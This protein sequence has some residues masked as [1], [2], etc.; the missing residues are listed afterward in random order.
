MEAESYVIPQLSLSNVL[1]SELLNVDMNGCDWYISVDKIFSSDTEGLENFAK[2]YGVKF[3]ISKISSQNRN[4]NLN[5]AVA[6]QEVK[7]YI[8]SGSHCAMIQGRMAKSVMI[9]KIVIKKVSLL[10]GKIDILVEMEFSNCVIQSF[11]IVGEVVFFTFCYM[12]CYYSYTEFNEDGTERGSVADQV[13]S[14]ADDS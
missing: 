10:M 1:P 8:G 14:S 7:I 9:P 12:S 2:F 6:L 11:S 3:Q 4:G 13:D 5:S